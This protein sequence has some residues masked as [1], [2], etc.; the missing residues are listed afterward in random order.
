VRLSVDLLY[1]H[2]LSVCAVAAED[3][4]W[5]AQLPKRAAAEVDTPV[6]EVVEEEPLIEKGFSGAPRGSFGWPVSS[7]KTCCGACHEHEACRHT[8]SNHYGPCKYDRNLIFD[9]LPALVRVSCASPR[10]PRDSGFDPFELNQWIHGSSFPRC[11]DSV[12]AGPEG[13]KNLAGEVLRLI[14]IRLAMPSFEK[15]SPVVK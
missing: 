2:P 12:I 9:P 13:A 5:R 7:E 6:P 14:Q 11:V 1:S 3:V 15:I 8:Q 10:H 4:D